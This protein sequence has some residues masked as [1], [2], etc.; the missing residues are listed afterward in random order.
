MADLV[1]PGREAD[2][3]SDSDR[4]QSPS[5]RRLLRLLAVAVVGGG[6]ALIGSGI[7]L[8]FKTEPAKSGL[9]ASSVPAAGALATVGN[10]AAKVRIKVMYFQMASSL[11]GIREE[12][13]TLQGPARY[14]Q[15]L[16]VVTSEHPVLTGM[17]P[18]MLVLVDGIVAKADTPLSDGD[19]VD[20]I[21]TVAGG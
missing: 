2:A 11:P 5:R 13:I 19:E 12:Y 15:L 14:S 9:T 16:G 8:N 7:V 21:P 10:Q 6:A 18:T 17:M 4:P 1:S 3:A 20:F